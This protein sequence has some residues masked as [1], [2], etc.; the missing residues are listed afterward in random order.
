MRI[1][2]RR[3]SARVRKM[4]GSS[5]RQYRPVAEPL[6][7]RRLLSGGPTATITGS[8]ATDTAGSPIDLTGSASELNVT[9]PSVGNAGFEGVLVGNGYAYDP[10]G[11]SWSFSG[12]SGVSGN[13]S[14][15]TS[16][17]PAAPQGSQVAFL[18]KTGSFTQS[19]SGWAAG[20]YTISFDAARRGNYGGVEDFEVLVD[21]NVVGTFKPGTTSYQSYTTGSFTVS[22]GS[23][24]VEFLGINTAGGDDTDFLDAVA[25]ATATTPAT[26]TVGTRGS[27]RCRWPPAATCTT[28]AGRLGRSPARRAAARG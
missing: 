25:F 28:R 18:Q 23:H 19:V 7:V 14:G 22:A 8:P 20:S 15:F 13:D 24:A 27:R 3:S 10:A 5:R 1:F 17:N 12:S 21:G 6:E 4:Q 9:P 26:P 2:E 11:S 16:G